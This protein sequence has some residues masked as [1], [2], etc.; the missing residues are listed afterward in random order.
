[1]ATDDR[2]RAAASRNDCLLNRYAQRQLKALELDLKCAQVKSF[3]QNR[4]HSNACDSSQAKTIPPLVDHQHH[5]RHLSG[6]ESEDE[7]GDFQANGTVQAEHAMSEIISPDQSLRVDSH[8]T[9]AP[10]DEFGRFQSHSTDNQLDLW[11]RLMTCIRRTLTRCCDLLLTSQTDEQF[12][13]QALSTDRGRNFC[14]GI[15]FT[16]W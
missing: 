2:R 11:T 7:F 15:Y 5:H 12:V 6:T 14:L 3:V 8:R 4:R 9:V 1:M 13:V 16:F 10:P